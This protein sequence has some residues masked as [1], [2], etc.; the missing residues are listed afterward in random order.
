MAHNNNDD[1]V[2]KPESP[3][4][5]KAPLRPEDSWHILIVDDDKEV[6]EVTRLALSRLTVLGR[7]LEL[8]HTSSA[9]ECLQF[10]EDRDNIAVIL[11]DVVMETED[12]GLSAVRY[13]R[14][15]M[16]R[17]EVRIIL[18]T[19]QPGYAPEE[20][21]VQDYDI[22]DYKTKSELT[23]STLTT[24][25]ISSIRSYQQIRTINQNR[26]GLQKIIN[27]GASL[28]EQHS[29]EEFSDGVITQISSL[30]GLRA[31]GLLCAQA[32][33]DEDAEQDDIYIMGAAGSY[34]PLIRHQLSR[35]DDTHISSLI[36]TCLQQKQHL[37]TDAE[38]VLYLGNEQHTAAVYLQTRCPISETD[39]A[40]LQVFL[41]N[42]TIGYENVKLFQELRVTAYTDPLTRLANRI[43]FTR[44][45]QGRVDS[46]E[47]RQVAVLVDIDHFSDINDG[48][49]QETG[50]ELLIAVAS[51]LKMAFGDNCVVARVD[52]DVFGIVGEEFNLSP[53]SILA[54]F[55]SPFSTR[56]QVLS[57]NA[58]LGIG[59]LHE[60]GDHGLTMLK[61]VYIALNSAKKENTRHFEY[62]SPEMEEAKEQR[63]QMIRQLRID[64][65]LQKLRIWYQPQYDLKT[66]RIVC[67]EALL[68]WP[69][70][71][72]SFIPPGVFIPIAEYSGLII[73]IGAWV[74]ENVCAQI[75]MFKAAGFKD[76]RIAV[77]VSMP[78][79][80]SPLFV[81]HVAS[82]LKRHNIANGELEL[83]ITESV[84]MDDPEALIQ[85][86]TK[87]KALG[88]RISID[89]FGTGYSSLN[90][91]RRLP[92][93][94]MKVDRSFIR[95]IGKP[96]GA[97]IAETIVHLGRQL[98]LVTIAEGIETA[99]QE[100]IMTD[101]GCV[102]AQGYYFAKPMPLEELAEL[103]K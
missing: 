75:A 27:A 73:S 94:K 102:E 2:F 58:T 38:T 85:C 62:Y 80:R 49:G 21:V 35:I 68:R 18:R 76:L 60:L 51:R 36:N 5:K 7:P 77:N 54:I 41:S 8:H 37:Y 45:L 88:I 14:N 13:I 56:D 22:N 20:N 93:D 70:A 82:A 33:L 101:M 46:E 50:N 40:L 11:I 81:P 103:L 39:K 15:T 57:I 97:V 100:Q 3:V 63:L 52:A 84:M 17:D 61:R 91:L 24:V 69:Q 1:I 67:L 90:Y 72:G 32:R 10:L 34:A 23:H 92:L 44:L 26:K 47:A 55:E 53:Q 29:L 59:R 71:D 43:E 19:G 79:F 12:A 30:L 6:H 64:F 42:I 48:L 95:D 78:Q 65:A 25:M 86:L 16:A 28:M 96:G 89:D 87:L 66:R 4:Q 74:L 31:E 9:A 99:E 83:E 98:G